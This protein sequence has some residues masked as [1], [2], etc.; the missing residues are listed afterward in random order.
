MS[1]ISSRRIERRQWPYERQAVFLRLNAEPTAGSGSVRGRIGALSMTRFCV[2]RFRPPDGW[3]FAHLEARQLVFESGHDLS[4]RTC[5]VVDRLCG[6]QQPLSARMPAPVVRRGRTNPPLS[7]PHGDTPRRPAGGLGRH[8]SK[9]RSAASPYS[10]RDGL[11]RGVIAI[12]VG[13]WHEHLG[14][15]RPHG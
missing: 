3:L 5:P 11:S 10:R 2:L 7:W 6:L 12:T 1:T 15:S 9:H 13:S 4:F 14:N 8:H